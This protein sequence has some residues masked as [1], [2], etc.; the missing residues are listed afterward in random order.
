MYRK[1]AYTLVSLACERQV[2]RYILCPARSDKLCK[3]ADY[4]LSSEMS[5]KL[6]TRILVIN[7]SDD[8]L[9]MFQKILATDSCEVFPQIFLNSD[10][11]EVRKI[12]PDLIILDFYV[13]REGVGWEFLQLLKMETTT[14][15][16][17][18][19][20]CTTA[21]R[22]AL[23]C[24]IHSILTLADPSIHASTFLPTPF[25]IIPRVFAQDRLL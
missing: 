13:G 8:I 14:A 5:A 7:N 2:S 19:L 21:V 20:I 18:V 15:L 1:D 3:G 17:P 23:V 16:I 9:A 4:E 12:R 24:G 22:L 10:L 11:R 25:P 6:T